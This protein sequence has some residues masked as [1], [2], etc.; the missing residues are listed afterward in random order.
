MTGVVRNAWLLAL[1]WSVLLCGCG[2]GDN[3]ISKKLEIILD[4][5]LKAISA[6]IP[7]NDLMDSIHYTIVSYKSYSDGMYS[8]MAVVDFYFLKN[9]KTKITRKYRYFISTRQW[10]RYFNEY[11]F[12]G[13]SAS[14]KTK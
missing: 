2:E 13:D 8:R 7:K 9:V 1:A 12:Y 11:R 10:D 3:L 6:D 4:G 14:T 5:D